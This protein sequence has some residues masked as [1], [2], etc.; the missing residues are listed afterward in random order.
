[1]IEGNEPRNNPS[2]PWVLEMLIQEKLYC[3]R[4]IETQDN[5][6]NFYEQTEKKYLRKYNSKGGLEGKYK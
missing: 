2:M 6:R 5:G 3:I 4:K 1:M